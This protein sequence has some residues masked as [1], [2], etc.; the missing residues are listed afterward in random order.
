VLKRILMVSGAAVLVLLVTVGAVIVTAVNVRAVQNAIV[1]RVNALLPGTISFDRLHVGLLSGTVRIDGATLADS[2]GR[3]LARVDRFFAKIDLAALIGGKLTVD[4]ASAVGARVLIET[5]AS[6]ML[7]IVS[8]IVAVNGPAAPRDSAT[9]QLP[10]RVRALR[11]EGGTLLVKAGDSGTTVS[12]YGLDAHAGGATATDSI[13][14]GAQADS[15]II[16]GKGWR[17]PFERVALFGRMHIPDIDTITVDARMGGSSISA[18]G[19]L[20]APFDSLIMD[21]GLQFDG[22]LTDL[23]RG[24]GAGEA[25]RCGAQMNLRV[26]GTPDNPDVAYILKFNDGAPAGFRIDSLALSGLLRDRVLTIA[27]LHLEHPHGNADANGRI[28]AR[29]MFPAGLTGP[30]A[31]VENLRYQMSA[32]TGPVSLAGIAGSLTGSARVSVAVDG[33]GVSPATMAARVTAAATVNS[34]QVASSVP[35]VGGGVVCTASVAGGSIL[36]R[37]CAGRLDGFSVN[38]DG[39]YHIATGGI[40][41]TA[42]VTAQAIDSLF[43]TGG[44]GPFKGSVAATARLS[45]T[46]DRPQAVLSLTGSALTWNRLRLG[47]ATM[48]ADLDNTGM[49]TLKELSLVNNSSSLLFSG[50]A[51]LFDR[52]R[53]LPSDSIRFDV[54]GVSRRFDFADVTD[55]VSGTVRLDTRLS[56]TPGDIRG[57]IQ[58]EGDTIAAAGFS[59]PKVR[60][61]GIVL[62]QRLLFDPFT[63]SLDGGKDLSLAGWVSARDSFEVRLDA[64]GV[65]LA[66]ALG[67]LGAGAVDGMAAVRCRAGGI[68]RNPEVSGSIDIG[69]V[70]WGGAT[71]DSTSLTFDLADSALTVAG[72]AAGGVLNGACDFGTSRFTVKYTVS[73]LPLAPLFALRGSGFSGMATAD[74]SLAGSTRSPADAVGAAD[75]R[76][77]I[78]MY[79]SLPVV[80]TRQLHATLDSGRYTIPAMAVTFAG[81]GT[82]RGEASG[83]LEGPHHAAVRGT[84]PLKVLDLFVSGLDSAEGTVLVDASFDGMPDAYDLG[85][86]VSLR[87]VGMAIPGIEQRLSALSGEIGIVRNVVQFNS[88]RGRIGTGDLRIGGELVLDKKMHPDMRM[89]VDMSGVPASIPGMLDLLLDGRFRITGRIDSALIAGD[90]VLLDGVY[91]KDV[92]INPLDGIG[93]RRRSAP[94]AAHAAPQFFD[95]TRFDIGI[96]A[97]SPLRVDNNIAQLSIAPDLHFG[98]TLAIPALSGRADVEQGEVRYLGN[99]FVIERGVVDFIS[100]YAVEPRIDV[101]ATDTVQDRIVRV[102]LSGPPEDLSFKL[103]CD[104]PSLNDEDILS[105]LLFGKT[106]AELQGEM[107]PGTAGGMSNRRMLAALAA[108]T[109]GETIRKAGGLDEFAIETGEQRNGATD[110]IALTVGKQL[111]R[112]LLTSYTVESDAGEVVQRAVAQYRL[113]QN[114]RIT[115]YQDTRGVFGGGIRFSWERR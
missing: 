9:A 4:T 64:P 44:T 65:P 69:I 84:L 80:E 50:N 106:T 96:T 38:A 45:G 41:A 102:E 49:L 88:L 66:V 83:H 70:R 47:N 40:A 72:K 61:N 3:E 91:Y 36:V 79:D 14:V 108:S 23:V 103:T 37:R 89:S 78:L 58:L 93:R 43:G 60:C 19:R 51:Q 34:L 35:A 57:N 12:A 59:I 55:S 94:A 81:E 54:T 109:F 2:A 39:S 115:G 113:L 71:I 107:K 48:F 22:I 74:I 75:I 97:R 105:L 114:L 87:N 56:G 68:Y 30:T 53:I 100:P 86:R 110:R 67:P 20:A 46:T 8:A 112:R 101:V 82:L 17:L 1:S 26:Q 32:T 99:V 76:H 62:G 24:F 6:G 31:S 92:T 27:S 52:G 73:D 18:A 63:V 42:S 5:D 11:I 29:E 95:A 33:R 104:D 90:A 111:T 25:W 15:L 98:G 16:G 10:V 7:S 28:D 21:V 77:L 13:G 85:A